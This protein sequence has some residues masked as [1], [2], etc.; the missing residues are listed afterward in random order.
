MSRKLLVLLLTLFTILLS[1]WLP[2]KIVGEEFLL[3]DLELSLITNQN[4][5]SDHIFDPIFIFT[6]FLVGVIIAICGQSALLLSFFISN[7]R[8]KSRLLK[9]TVCALWLS[10]LLLTF[11]SEYLL[12]S[13]PF[14]ISSVILFVKSGMGIKKAGK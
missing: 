11:S 8:I 7:A 12:F 9:I 14:I 13:I 4:P 1:L 3:K 6:S 5:S 10:L 2:V